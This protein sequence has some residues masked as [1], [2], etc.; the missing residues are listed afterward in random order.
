MALCRHTTSPFPSQCWP[1]SLSPHGVIRPQWFWYLLTPNVNVTLSSVTGFFNEVLDMTHNLGT[2]LSIGEVSARKRYSSAL[3]MELRVFALSNRYYI[4]QM[5]LLNEYQRIA[6]VISPH[7]SR[8]ELC[9]V[10]QQALSRAN[11]DQNL[12]PHM[13]SLG[14]NEVIPSIQS[15]RASVRWFTLSNTRT[16]PFGIFSS[17][18]TSTQPSS[19]SEVTAII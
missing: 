14:H 7:W 3:A 4:V 17:S 18:S 1:K 12:C 8:Q 11:V 13:P 19:S 15:Y 6:L 9:A 16:K 5:N 2:D 10:R